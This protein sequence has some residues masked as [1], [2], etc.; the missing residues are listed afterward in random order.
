MGGSGRGT[1][2]NN[3][4]TTAPARLGISAQRNREEGEAAP[5]VMPALERV[6]LSDDL[7]GHNPEG[8]HVGLHR[9]PAPARG[10]P[11]GAQDLGGRPCARSLL[12]QPGTSGSG[13]G[14]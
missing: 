14:V 3:T 6:G 5:D 9:D 13:F 8:V 1:D 7:P 4:A 12:H 2:F 10:V 11:E